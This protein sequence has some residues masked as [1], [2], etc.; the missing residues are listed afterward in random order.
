M[1]VPEWC[2]AQEYMLN[3]GNCYYIVERSRTRLGHNIKEN[4]DLCHSAQHMPSS[5]K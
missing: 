1:K 4:N 2:L 3:V 5:A